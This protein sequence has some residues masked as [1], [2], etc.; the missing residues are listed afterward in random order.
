MSYTVTFKKVFTGIMQKDEALALETAARL[1]GSGMVTETGL[2]NYFDTAVQKEP[3]KDIIITV[4]VL[5]ELIPEHEEGAQPTEAELL[6]FIDFLELDTTDW[7][8]SNWRS[9][10]SR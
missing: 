8:M 2:L 9:F 5:A 7:I 6:E 1:L 4:E 10:K 3:V